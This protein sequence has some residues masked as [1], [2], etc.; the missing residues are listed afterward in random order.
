MF[1]HHLIV[2]TAGEHRDRLTDSTSRRRRVFGRKSK[3]G[4]NSSLA[5]VVT[6]PTCMDR[7]S[8]GTMRVA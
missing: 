2:V 4:S 7:T 5:D 6:L 1:S 8:P 3:A